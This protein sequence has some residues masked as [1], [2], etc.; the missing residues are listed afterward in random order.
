MAFVRAAKLSDVPEGQA[1]VVTLGETEVALGNVAGQI[2]AVANL[3]TH[4]GGPLGE[5]ELLD[6]QIECPRHGARFDLRSGAV[7]AL[8][9]VVPIPIYD[10]KVEGDDILVDMG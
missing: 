7:R 10:V 9:A 1:V 4:D 3:C 8:P 6:H 2:Y 5:G